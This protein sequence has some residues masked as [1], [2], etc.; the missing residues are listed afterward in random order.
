VDDLEGPVGGAGA[1]RDVDEMG[2]FED[3][4]AVPYA[5][6]HDECI[7][8]PERV[9]CLGARVVEVAIVEHDFESAG[10]EIQEFVAIGM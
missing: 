2:R 6:R 10:D 4:E 8:G 5:L 1:W 7:A 3:V 9:A